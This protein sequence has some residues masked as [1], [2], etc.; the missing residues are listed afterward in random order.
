MLKNHCLAR[1]IAQQAS[2]EFRRQLTYKTAWAGKR[3]VV[4][5]RF[6]PSSKRCSQCTVTKSFLRRSDRIFHCTACNATLNRD[7]NAAIN[8]AQE[9]LRI[10][11]ASAEELGKGKTP[12]LDGLGAI[13]SVLRELSPRARSANAKSSKGIARRKLGGSSKERVD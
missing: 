1:F 5:D 13:V 9:T 4:V 6:L 12:E 2:G 8:T 11:N 3:L 10:K 7:D